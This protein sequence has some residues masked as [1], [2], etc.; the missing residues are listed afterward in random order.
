MQEA[1]GAGLLLECQVC[2]SDDCLESDMVACVGGHLF[3]KV[4]YLG[5]GT[6]YLV[7]VASTTEYLPKF[8]NW[9]DL[10]VSVQIWFD[11]GMLSLSCLNILYNLPVPILRS[12]VYPDLYWILIQ[13][14]CRSGSAF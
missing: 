4:N 10:V 2:F 8:S 5:P 13:E 7:P 14:P 9:I 1:R 6:W 3:C 11:T 12:V